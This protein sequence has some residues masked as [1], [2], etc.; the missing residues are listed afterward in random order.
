MWI[1]VAVCELLVETKT[2]LAAGE[3][4]YWMERAEEVADNHQTVFRLKEYLIK[5]ED[6]SG[7]QAQLIQLAESMIASFLL[8][9]LLPKSLR[10]YCRLYFTIYMLTMYYVCFRG[11]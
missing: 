8:F 1:H 10:T 4:K 3:A 5:M 9:F 6:G 7:D 2:K 11:N